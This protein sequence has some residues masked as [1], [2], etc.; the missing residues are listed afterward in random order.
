VP[1][2]ILTCVL[3]S[4]FPPSVKIIV[5]CSLVVAEPFDCVAG[6]TAAQLSEQACL[7]LP[8]A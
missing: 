6:R 1:M 4:I 8:S 5:R 2:I 3:R 7:L